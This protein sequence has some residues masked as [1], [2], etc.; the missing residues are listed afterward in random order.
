VYKIAQR[1]EGA[2]CVRLAL[3]TASAKSFTLSFLVRSSVT[4]THSGSFMNSAQNRSYPFTYTID[5]A[6]TWE[7]KSITVA[8]DTSGTW[9]VDNGIGL[10]LNFDLGSD[11]AKRAS[12]GSWYAGRAEGATGAVQLTETSNATW[13]ITKVQLEEGSSA[14]DFEH[15]SFSE[16]LS[17]CERY[18]QVFGDAG[19][20]TSFLMPFAVHSSSTGMGAPAYKCEMRSGPTLTATSVIGLTNGNGSAG[21]PDVATDYV[22][23]N[24][25]RLKLTNMINLVQGDASILQGGYVT[26]SAEL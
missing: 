1:I 2:D 11:A 20:N 26:L 13:E 14:T 12:A 4:G 18:F 21:N 15:R 9:L 25:L 19:G 16:E 7:S 23:K 24:S 8:G 3:G 17:R 5:S 6:D 22:R 10:E